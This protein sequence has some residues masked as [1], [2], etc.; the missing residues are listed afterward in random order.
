MRVFCQLLSLLLLPVWGLS[1]ADKTQIA[2]DMGIE[3]RLFQDDPADPR[4][5]GNNLSLYLKPEFYKKLSSRWSVTFRPFIRIDQSDKQRNHKDLRELLFHRVARKWELKLGV[6]KV[7]W[8]VTESQ[9]LVDVIN[10][11]D[12]IEASDGEE[13]LGQPMLNL[14]LKR[15]WGTTSLF[16]LPYFRERTFAGYRGRLRTIPPVDTTQALYESKRE[17]KHIDYAIR[18]S[19]TLGPWD[20][21]LSHFNGT[22]RVPDFT[23]GTN[24][25]GEQVLIPFY[26][27]MSQT[28]L[29][30]QLTKGSW[31]WKLEV[32]H[33]RDKGSTYKAT[34]YTALTGGFEYTRNGIFKTRADL[35][36]LVEY[37]YDD[38][39]DPTKTPFDSDVMFG[40]RLTFN[41]VA[42]TQLLGG[43][44][45]DTG[46]SERA[47]FIE[48]SRRIGQSYKLAIEARLSSN[49]GPGSPLYSLR[50]DDMLQIEFIKYF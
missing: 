13:K 46:T 18:W 35:G 3:A 23:A 12:A 15:K 2:G 47:Y 42:S 43:V 7:F 36:L 22:S 10:Q 41:D 40:A 38:R 21:G 5:R 8:G 20:I 26:K 24:V 37:L 32:I 39:N 50:N 19:R 11:T 31:L 4:Q 1:W 28:G 30:L 9:H 16:I 44:I 29:D 34:P 45:L 17:E 27:Q 48:F 25:N 14:L 33:R 6:S 49:A